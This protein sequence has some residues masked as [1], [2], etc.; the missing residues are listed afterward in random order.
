MQPPRQRVRRLPRVACRAIVWTAVLHAAAAF[1]QAPARP[2][3]ALDAQFEARVRAVMSPTDAPAQEQALAALRT[4]DSAELIPRLVRFSAH[5][6]NTRE[7]MAAGVII[8]RLRL[9][10]SAVIAGLIPHLGTEDEPFDAS[11]RGILRSYEGRDGDRAPDFSIYREFVES[12]ARADEHPPESLVLYLYESD[13]G[14]ALMLMMR[15]HGLRDPTEIKAVL[16]GE[17]VVADALWRQRY[18][19][20]EPG[21]VDPDAARELSR[22]ATSSQWWAR[23]YVA[24][25]LHQHAVFRRDGLVAALAHDSHALVRRTAAHLDSD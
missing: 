23:L 13:P 17:H 9:S 12:A 3:P 11:I 6:E 18:G 15:A 1:A 20:L 21:R 25:I 16:W 2:A 5:A 7:G 8:E 14:A 19:F 4:M 24:E 10:R 22:L